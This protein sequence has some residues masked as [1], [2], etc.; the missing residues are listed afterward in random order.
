MPYIYMY[1]VS[2]VQESRRHARVVKKASK[3]AV[4]ELLDIVAMKGMNTAKIEDLV[5]SGT[6][7]S[8]RD[9]ATSAPSSSSSSSSGCSTSKQANAPIAAH[10]PL[11]AD[12]GEAVSR[13]A[14]DSR[15]PEGHL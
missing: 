14:E 10:Q 4:S 13:D 1:I 12:V 3:L 15:L 5:K 8:D 9:D 6:A 11:G 2:H 7:T